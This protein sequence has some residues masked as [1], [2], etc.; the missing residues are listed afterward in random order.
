MQNIVTRI[1]TTILDEITEYEKRL[2][3]KYQINEN[4]KL[5][6]HEFRREPPSSSK[7]GRFPAFPLD[8]IYNHIVCKLRFELETKLSHW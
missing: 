7:Q 2:L 4:V 8:D 5:I 6:Y 3:E 1:I